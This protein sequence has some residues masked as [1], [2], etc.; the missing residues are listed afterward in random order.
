MKYLA[1]IP[2][3]L[4]CIAYGYASDTRQTFE[5]N[6]DQLLSALLGAGFAAVLIW[7]VE[8][9]WLPVAHRSKRR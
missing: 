8:K 5:V 7:V 4:A 2:L 3:A 9:V 1:Y 6:M